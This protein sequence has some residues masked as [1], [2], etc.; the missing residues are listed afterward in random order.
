MAN[1]ELGICDVIGQAICDEDPGRWLTMPSPRI[2]SGR[3][4]G[5]QSCKPVAVN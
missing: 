1:T 3:G 5:A 4:D 2:R